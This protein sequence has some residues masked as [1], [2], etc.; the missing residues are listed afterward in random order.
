MVISSDEAVAKAREFANKV[1]WFTRRARVKEDASLIPAVWKVQLKGEYDDVTIEV[2]ADRGEVLKWHSSDPLLIA[3][4]RAKPIIDKLE[5]QGKPVDGK[6]YREIWRQEQAKVLKKQK[7]PRSPDLD[8]P[9]FLKERG[10][11]PA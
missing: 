9:P 3:Y 5:A 2:N 1:G 8:V 6:Q 4:E 7:E 11:R 10:K